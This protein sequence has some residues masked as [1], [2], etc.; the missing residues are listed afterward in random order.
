VAGVATPH[1][2]AFTGSR[3]TLEGLD[4]LRNSRLRAISARWSA[5]YMGWSLLRGGYH[6]GLDELERPKP[7]FKQSGVRLQAMPLKVRLPFPDTHLPSPPLFDHR[8]NVCVL[9]RSQRLGE[10][11]SG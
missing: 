1:P 2:L 6:T 9:D 4:A 3:T 11:L 7:F 10:V 5:F 8:K